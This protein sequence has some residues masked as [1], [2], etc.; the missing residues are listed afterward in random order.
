MGCVPVLQ[1]LSDGTAVIVVGRGGGHSP[2]ERPEGISMI[3]ADDGSTVWTLPLPGFM[4]TMTLN[5]TDDD[6]V[7]VFHGGE[8]HWVDAANGKITRTVSILDE[9]PTHVF[10]GGKWSTTVE[11]LKAGKKKREIIQQSNILTGDYHYFRSYTRPWLGRVN[12]RSGAV[13]YLQ[14][15]VQLQR[16]KDGKT[17]RLLWSPEDLPADTLQ[18]LRSRLKKNQSQIPITQWAFAPNDMKNSRG[19]V[20]MG[21]NSNDWAAVLVGWYGGCCLIE[22]SMIDRC[23]C[24]YRSKIFLKPFS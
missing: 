18:A 9:I 15:P 12:I 14:L 8:H 17:N 19:F 21:D 4:S 11:T 10:R 3:R 16:T 2:P 13:E 5:V 23:C 1:R 24:H 20:V 22:N 7:L 6:K